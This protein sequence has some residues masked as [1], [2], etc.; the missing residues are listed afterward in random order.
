MHKIH[1]SE[2]MYLVSQ[3]DNPLAKPVKKNR[4][5]SEDFH[6]VQL[7]MVSRLKI[8][9]RSWFLNVLFFYYEKVEKYDLPLYH[10]SDH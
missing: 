5:I 4:L 7:S 8:M 2:S 6:L 1:Y 10:F 3:E 9:T